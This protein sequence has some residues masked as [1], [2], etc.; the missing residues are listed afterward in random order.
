MH[1][2]ARIHIPCVSARSRNRSETMQ[3]WHRGH[4]MNSLLCLMDVIRKAYPVWFAAID[5]KGVLLQW[6]IPMEQSFGGRRLL[7]STP[8]RYFLWGRAVRRNNTHYQAIP[9]ACPRGWGRD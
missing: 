7:V 6:G 9:L 3:P 2:A 4:V 1:R 8:R 5:M